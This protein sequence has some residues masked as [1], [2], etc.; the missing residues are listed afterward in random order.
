[1]ARQETT[2]S[3]QQYTRFSLAQ[4]I[5]HIILIA[6]FTT[7][8]LTGLPQK[9]AGS[10]I[11]EAMIRFLGGIETIRVIHHTAAII[12]VL[13]SVYHVV[14][15]AYKVFVRRDAMSMLPGMRDVT[16]AVGVVLYNLGLAKKRPLLPRYGFEEKAEYWA[17][18]WGTVMMALTGFMLWNP[19][20]ITRIL[21]GEIVPAAKAAHGGEAVL[22]VLAI[23]VW[24][25]YNV[26]L[27]GFNTAM[28]TGKLSRHAMEE[29]HG[30]ELAG[31]EAA[32]TRPAPP[33]QV[34][35]RRMRSFVPAA[36]IFA[37]LGVA[38]VYWAAASEK[39]AIT[40]LPVVPTVAVFA[41]LPTPTVEISAPIS[42][43][44]QPG[45]AGVAVAIPHP[46]AG[47]EKCSQCHA[48]GGI[49]PM[50]ADHKGRT[51]DTCTACHKL[52][53]GVSGT[54][55]AAETPTGGTPAAGTPKPIP[56]SIADAA[57]KDCLT[58]H[59]ATSAIK[60]FPAN[61]TDFTVDQ[62]VNCH[63]APAGETAVAPATPAAG[64]TPTAAAA[65][66][67]VAFPAD[68]AAAPDTFKDC[69][70]CHGVGKMKPFPASHASYTNDICTS[71]HTTGTP[72]A[73]A[74][75]PAAGDTPTVTAS[76]AAP[77]GVPVAI[78]AN[79]AAAPDTFKD[80]VSCHGVGKMKPF[81]AS[82]AS[83]TNDMCSGCHK[84]TS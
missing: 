45:A 69:V 58:C 17:M 16:D 35:Q 1:M 25:F 76:G 67:P 40:T 24:H 18:L 22:A 5:E 10:G 30:L 32:S 14:I 15:L 9:Y 46:I 28:W 8:A 19:I 79:H 34:V 4:R 23:I 64:E 75:T 51:D 77:A 3:K 41:P 43:T 53:P 78:P 26:H 50:P 73:G 38:F 84:P 20:T 59:G 70:S 29:E 44:A 2:L 71:C 68:H 36:A 37:L 61:H 57:H 48:E 81:P 11:A 63:Q 52:S 13:E 12:F 72:G 82:H 83:Y 39:T 80:C 47:R 42:G 55:Q 7:L 65:G 54:P 49:K 74:A 56:H 33:P 60:P 62:C 6:S 66:V 31:L 21:P 27:K